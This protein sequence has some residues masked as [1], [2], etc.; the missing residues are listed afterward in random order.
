MFEQSYSIEASQGV[1]RVF[2]EWTTLASL[3]G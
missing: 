2:F 3:A 1:S